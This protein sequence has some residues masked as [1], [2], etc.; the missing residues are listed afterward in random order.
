MAV[1]KALKIDF[2]SYGYFCARLL[3]YLILGA[4]ISQKCGIKKI[5]PKKV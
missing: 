4:N 2:P 1:I 3:T 5:Y